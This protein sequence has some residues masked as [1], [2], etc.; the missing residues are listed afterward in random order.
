MAYV[1]CQECPNTHVCLACNGTKIRDAAEAEAEA[2]HD[3]LRGI[4]Y[5]MENRSLLLSLPF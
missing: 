5:D 4:E 2:A 1:L 3:Y